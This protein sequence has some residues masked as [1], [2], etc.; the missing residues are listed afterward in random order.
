MQ[1]VALEEHPL[2]KSAEQ[3]GSAAK[4]KLDEWEARILGE[5]GVGRESKASQPATS[6]EAA[7]S[8]DRPSS[9]YNSKDS[10]FSNNVDD[11][12]DESQ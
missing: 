9:G 4:R 3:R 11:A 7:H 10:D 12:A 5:L 2:L 1:A 6:N 8:F